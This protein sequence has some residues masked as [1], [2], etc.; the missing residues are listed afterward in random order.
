MESSIQLLAGQ[1]TAFE[2]IKAF[3]ENENDVFILKGYAGTGKTT[4]IKYIT[5]Y[6]KDRNL[7]EIL[8]PTGRAAKILRNKTNAGKTI[9]SQ[10]FSGEL[11]CK[12]HLSEDKSKKNFVFIFPVKTE[13]TTLKT[14]IVDESSMVSDTKMESDFLQFGSGKLL[15]DLLEY[16]NNC[17]IK[18]IIFIGDPAQLPPV[19]DNHSNALEEQYFTRKGLK[20]ES[21]EL[22]EVIRQNTD[23][24]ILTEAIKIRQLLKQ[25]TQSRLNFILETDEKEIVSLDSSEMVRK[26][27]ELFPIPEFNNGIMICY[28]NKRAYELNTA[29]REIY[30]PEQKTVKPGDILLVNTNNQKTGLLNGDLVKVLEVG[31]IEDHKNIPVTIDKE[32]RHITLSF[33]DIKLFYINSEGPVEIN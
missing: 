9:H 25:D 32:K 17:G 2:R 13:T 4:L 29:I 6:L 5:D 12:E 21:Y 8:A 24:K 14:I 18:K 28:S 1:Q 33:R 19:G 30:F 26:Y 3:L 27:T 15:T 16:K 11:I 10:I 20:T 7:Y 31:E 22:T 23:S